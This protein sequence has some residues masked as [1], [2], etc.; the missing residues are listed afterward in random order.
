M[1]RGNTTTKSVGDGF[2]LKTTEDLKWE[3]AKAEIEMAQLKREYG[4]ISSQNLYYYKKKWRRVKD[5]L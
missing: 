3:K 5:N 2:V 4:E 1:P